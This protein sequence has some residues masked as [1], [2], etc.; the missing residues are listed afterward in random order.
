MYWAFPDLIIPDCDI[1]FCWT[2]TFPWS[3]SLSQDASGGRKHDLII[4]SCDNLSELPPCI[5]TVDVTS[6]GGLG[7]SFLVSMFGCWCD[8]VS[9][10]LFLLWSFS[11]PSSGID[12]IETHADGFV[13][14]IGSEIVF[15]YGECTG[16]SPKSTFIHW[17]S[18]SLLY[19]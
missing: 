9:L 14:R 18:S 7:V 11:H 3:V 19:F 13:A 17:C 16:V 5:V 6:T 10:C 1:L 8:L 2:F 15:S 12:Q 4:D